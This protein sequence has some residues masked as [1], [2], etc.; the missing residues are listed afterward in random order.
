[1]SSDNK[2]IARK[3]I[4]MFNQG[5]LDAVAELFS[6]NYLY[7]GPTGDLSGFAGWRTLAQMYRTAF[8]DA[9][10]SID[11]QVAEGDRVVTRCTARGTHAGPLGSV[12]ASGKIVVV[13]IILI[14]RIAGGRLV[15]TW[16]VFDQL[17]MLQAI[18]AIPVEAA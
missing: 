15:E 7:H 8:P 12:S 6:T 4:E 10:M 11:D 3:V 2:A 13:P 14:D 18:G 17:G 9:V 16:E 5:K 1:M